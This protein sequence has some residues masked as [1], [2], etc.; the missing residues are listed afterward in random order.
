MKGGLQKRGCM[1]AVQLGGYCNTSGKRWV[2]ATDF[3]WE[4]REGRVE[5]DA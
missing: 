3:I 5:N 1:H 2:Q 4:V